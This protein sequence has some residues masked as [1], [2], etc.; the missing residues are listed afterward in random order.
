MSD[1]EDKQLNEG[2]SGQPEEVPATA[3]SD[4]KEVAP[5]DDSEQADPVG[6]AASPKAE[7]GDS[8]AAEAKE[9]KPNAAA[10]KKEKSKATA[11]ADDESDEAYRPGDSVQ[12]KI[13]GYPWWPAV[14]C[15]IA[16][17]PLPRLLTVTRSL[18]QS[19]SQLQR[20][21]LARR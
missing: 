13:P 3:T 1:T 18:L 4:D 17:A 6:R 12:V 19:I 7:N 8:D 5:A 16:R 15:N 11:K 14:V 2:A 10:T 21:L 20:S 9:S